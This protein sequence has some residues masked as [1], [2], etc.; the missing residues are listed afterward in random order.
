LAREEK[1]EDDYNDYIGIYGGLGDDDEN[2]PK[3]KA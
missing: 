2:G 3:S 1:L